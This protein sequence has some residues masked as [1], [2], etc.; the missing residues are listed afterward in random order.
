MMRMF[1]IVLKDLKQIFQDQRTLIFLLLMPM[2]FTLFMGFAYGSGQDDKSAAPSLPLAWVNLDSDWQPIESLK[3]RLA[4]TNPLQMEAM[5]ETTALDALHSGRVDGV[6]IIPAGFSQSATNGETLPLTLI[7]DSSSSNG[8]LLYQLL[9]QS[10]T[11][12]MSSLKIAMLDVHALQGTE[13]ATEFEAAFQTAWNRWE[14]TENAARIQTEFA[15]AEAAPDPFGG[16]PYNQASPGI[17]LMFAM[18]GLMNSAQVLLNERKNG[19]LARMLTTSVR[20]SVAVTGHFLAMFILTFSQQALLVAFGQLFLEVNY[21]RVPLGV[22]AVMVALSL[23]TAG[24][25]LLIGAVAR[26]EQQVSL[27]SL[28]VMFIFSGLGGAWFPLEVAG[29]TFA[30][31]GQWMPTAWAMT[32]FQNILIRGQSASSAI[33]PSGILLVYASVFCTLAV[34]RLRK[35][36]E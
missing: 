16:N 10:V 6:L 5:N 8:T 31:I 36:L 25:G 19:T 13:P 32:G 12:W 28:I 35:S 17:L 29:K 34:W 9:R 1:T 3:A 22:L 11:Q 2:V 30:T 33:W 27:Y 7:T 15:T 4:A 20:P 18:F 24:L 14:K 26:E 21:L 23:A